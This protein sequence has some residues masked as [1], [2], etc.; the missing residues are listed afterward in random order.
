MAA[1]FAAGVS[2]GGACSSAW[3][4]DDD[5]AVGFAAV[6]VGACSA[7]TK[8]GAMREGSAAPV[9]MLE[10]L[11]EV[12]CASP[13]DSCLLAVSGDDDSAEPGVLMLIDVKDDTELSTGVLDEDVLAVSESLE[14]Y[15]CRARALEAER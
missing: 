2:V 3:P 7:M 14:I 6:N 11:V 8:T 15:G 9:M 5:D 13:D 1:V 4:D 10:V 12:A